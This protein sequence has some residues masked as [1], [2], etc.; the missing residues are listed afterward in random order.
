MGQR[1]LLNDWV[2]E[3]LWGGGGKHRGKINGDYFSKRSWS[4]KSCLDEWTSHGLGTADFQA[5]GM[6]WSLPSTVGELESR[7]V[8]KL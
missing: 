2:T 1:G 5:G 6:Q 7:L 3:R 4:T 8:G